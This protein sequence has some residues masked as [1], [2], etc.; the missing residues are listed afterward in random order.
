[1]TYTVYVDDNAH[2]MDEDSRYKL[3]DFESLE[4]AKEAARL[5]LDEWIESSRKPGKPGSDLY[6]EYCIF[7]EDPFIVGPDNGRIEFSAREYV[8]N[9]TERMWPNEDL[10]D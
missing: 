9:R 4:L 5:L 6:K 2:Y 8:R 1:M 7:G 3:G 10:T